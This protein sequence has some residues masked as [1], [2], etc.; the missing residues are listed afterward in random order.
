MAA[1]RGT[2]KGGLKVVPL[3]MVQPPPE[4]GELQETPEFHDMNAM[5]GDVTYVPGFSEQRYA[6]DREI[7][8]VVTGNRRPQDVRSLTHNFRWARCQS[9]KGE[10]DSRKVVKA[11]NRG[12]QAVT[13]EMVGE[14]KLVPTLPAGAVYAADGTV[15]QGDTQL[16]VATA[17]RVARNEFNKRARTEAS[18]R[19]AE[20]GF[21]AALEAVGGRPIRGA[22]PF[23]QKEVGKPVEL[24]PKPKPK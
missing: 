8:E 20:A 5:N 6:R 19:G 3:V 18:T 9:K 16:M 17:A 15:R 12:Y 23:I 2:L 10:P 22:A 4:F 11:G 13:K 1:K 7:N 21:E 24:D 14:G